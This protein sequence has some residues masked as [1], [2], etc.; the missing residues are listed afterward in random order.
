LRTSR[1][2]PGQVQATERCRGQGAPAE[3]E[4]LH[5]YGRPAKAGAQLG[6]SGPQAFWGARAGQVLL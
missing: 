6:T 3:Q 1:S 4:V 5:H 2:A